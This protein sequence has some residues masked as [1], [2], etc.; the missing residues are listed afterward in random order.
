[1]TGKASIQEIRDQVNPSYS[2]TYSYDNLYRLTQAESSVWTAA[3]SYDRYGNRLSQTT[4]GVSYSETLSISSTSNRVSAWTYDD[5]GNVTNDGNHTYQYDA[6]N[7]LIGID[8]SATAV[9]AYGPQGERVSKTTGGI[10][11]YFYWGIGEKVNGKLD[12]AVRLRPRW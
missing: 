6:E 8:G 11:T 3:W 4:T 9:Y 1:M 12:E 10:T 7:R 5:A 2:E